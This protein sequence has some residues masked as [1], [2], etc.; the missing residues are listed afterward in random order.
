MTAVAIVVAAV[1]I[2]GAEAQDQPGKVLPI[3]SKVLDIAGMTLGLDAMLKDLGAKVTEKEIVIEL[4][5]D[6]LFDF[7]KSNLRPEAV[8]ALT[9]VAAILKGTGKS[10]ATIEGHTDGKGS[11]AYNQPLSERRAQSVR[12][13]L[14][15]QGGIEA[16]RLSAKGFGKI[17]PVAP[18]AKP[19]GSD[20]PDGRQKNRRVEIRVKKS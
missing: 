14:V 18:N 12:D 1:A 19:D 16:S 13:W 4:S 15:K 5:A 7:D 8:D 3:E 10:P 2:A 11:D 17:R 6:V 20:D 9:K